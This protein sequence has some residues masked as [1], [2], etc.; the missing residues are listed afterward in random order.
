M[1]VMIGGLR[2]SSFVFIA[3]RLFSQ[4]W[5][6]YILFNL[7]ALLI[8]WCSFMLGNFIILRLVNSFSWLPFCSFSHETIKVALTF[9]LETIKCALTFLLSPLFICIL[10]LLNWTDRNMNL[11]FIWPLILHKG[12]INRP[13]MS[14]KCLRW[15]RFT[16]YL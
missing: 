10:S 8:L 4:N 11:I 7:L 5:T 12:L 3:F 13:L 14:N 1:N 2:E 6:F 16:F 9:L 15:C